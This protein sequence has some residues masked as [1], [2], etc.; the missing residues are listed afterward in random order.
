MDDYETKLDSIAKEKERYRVG[1]VAYNAAL[2][3][4]GA[5][6]TAGIEVAT[7]ERNKTEGDLTN[8]LNGTGVSIEKDDYGNIINTEAILEAAAEKYG[9]DS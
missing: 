9:P 7:E 1:S 5:L 6:Y 8:F 3:K 2:A 4:E